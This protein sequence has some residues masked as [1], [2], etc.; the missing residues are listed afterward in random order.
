MRPLR[1]QPPKAQR[2]R[3][4][5]P[6]LR[7]S[8]SRGGSFH[9]SREQ[10]NVSVGTG[11]S[12][13]DSRATKRKNR[14]SPRRHPPTLASESYSSPSPLISAVLLSGRSSPPLPPGPDR[15]KLSSCNAFLKLNKRS[16]TQFNRFRSSAP[17]RG[18]LSPNS[19]DLAVR[20]SGAFMLLAGVLAGPL[21]NGRSKQ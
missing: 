3:V 20:Q 15:C 13:R 1:A 10:G 11:G 8:I 4:G 18:P 17:A 2:P 14:S 12:V 21:F 9:L 16:T 19:P 7:S 6:T 5:Y